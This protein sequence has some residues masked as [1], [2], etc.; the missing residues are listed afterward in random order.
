MENTM[1]K[2]TKQIIYWAPRMLGILFVIFLS[3]FAFDVFDGQYSVW[4]TVLA[5]FMH[6]IPSIILALAVA[7]AWRWEWIGTLVFAGWAVLYIAIARGFPVSVYVIVAGIPFLIGIL[8]LVDWMY[9]K[10]LRAA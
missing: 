1:N 7:L 2:T 4:Q 3:L 9:R 6:L 8:F 5:L 10:E